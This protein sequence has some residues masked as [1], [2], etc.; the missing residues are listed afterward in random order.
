MRHR[1]VSL[2]I[3][4]CLSLSLSLS[5]CL[6]HHPLFL[7]CFL[8]HPSS[9]LFL[10]LRWGVRFAPPSFAWFFVGVFSWPF[11]RCPRTSLVCTGWPFFVDT[12]NSLVCAGWPF[13]VASFFPP[14]LSLLRSHGP[15]LG[16]PVG[17][18]FV[19]QCFV[20]LCGQA[21]LRWYGGCVGL[22]MLA[23][24]LRFPSFRDSIH[25]PSC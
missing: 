11:L 8:L 22:R 18:S 19:A 9:S 15:S 5:C 25:I 1:H 16:C 14:H 23:R 24:F 7:A 13:F 4:L 12:V 17:L 21:L 3:S 20:G 10:V 2:S 6:L